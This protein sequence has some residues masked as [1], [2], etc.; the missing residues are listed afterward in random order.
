MFFLAGK[1]R[2]CPNQRLEYFRDIE[3]ESDERSN[4]VNF[5]TNKYK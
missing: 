2:V 4:I 1:I 5:L 3:I